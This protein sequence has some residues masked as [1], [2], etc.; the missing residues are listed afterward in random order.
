[1]AWVGGHPAVSA[2]IIGARNVT[3]LEASLR[4]VEI[5]MTPK[6]R[7][8]IASLSPTPPPATDRNEEKTTINYGVR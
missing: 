6:L 5:E 2:P 8:E 7:S 3:Q 4:A 1:M